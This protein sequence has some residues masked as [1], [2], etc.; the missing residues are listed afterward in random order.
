MISEEW[1]INNGP[2]IDGTSDQSI[3]RTDTKTAPTPT[4]SSSQ[5]TITPNTSHD[6]DELEPQQQHVQQQDTQDPIQPK[7]IVDN[8]PN[9]MFD[10]DVFKNPFALHP[11]VLLN[12]HLH[13]INKTRL[14]V[15]GY[16]QEEGIDFKETFALVARMEAIK[17]FLAY[18]AH[19]SFIVIQMD[20]KTAFLH[21]SL[22]EDVYMCQ[23]KGFID[24]DHPTMSTR[25]TFKSTSGGTQFLGEK[26]LT[27][28]GF[29]FNKIPIYCDSKSAIAKSCNPVQHSRTK[30]IIV[31]YHFIKEHV[32][33]GTIELHFVK[34]D[35]QLAKI[36]TKALPVDRFN[37]LVRCLGQVD[38]VSIV[39]QLSHSQGH[40]LKA[41][42]TYYPHQDLR[43][44]YSS[45]VKSSI[46]PTAD[47]SDKHQQQNTTPSTSTTIV[48]DTTQLNIQTTPEPTIQAPTITTTENIDQAENVMVDEDEFI[49]NFG[50]PIHEVG[51][52]SSH[53]VDPSN[54]HTFYQKHPSKYH[55]T[56]DHPLEQDLRN[57]SQL[58]RIRRQLDID[59]E[60]CM[61]VLTMSRAEPKNI[62][63]AMA[64]HAWIEVWEVV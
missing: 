36:F 44:N 5:A 45:C 62:K 39:F 4:N 54:I 37:Y 1:P 52:S 18:D 47:A 56:R 12:H 28:Y 59:G 2:G 9:A 46:V 30:H 35:Y 51:E 14:V 31:C 32:E 61:F 26:L 25:D 10:G 64:N 34:T 53:Q 15:R 27:D 6:V 22:K 3:N 16:R 49:N 55:W 43:V 60:R 38:G 29:H 7:T 20:V 63:E 33:K 24:V 17:I 8:V 42:K 19:K 21:G 13:N 50:I 41:I 40:M 11:Q 48:A 23:P 57:P 58:V